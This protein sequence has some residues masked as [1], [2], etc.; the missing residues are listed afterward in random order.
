MAINGVGDVIA[1]VQVTTQ[2]AKTLHAA[3]HA[4]EEIRLFIRETDRYQACVG[5][6]A[7][8]LRRHGAIL[9]DHADVKSNI[10]S[11]LE[12]C[13]E[14]TRKLRR[15][16][17][18]YEHIVTKKGTATGADAA[19]NQWIEAFKTV[20]HSIEWTTKDV[21][22][23][24][25]RRELSRHIQILSWLENGLLSEQVGQLSVQ[26]SNLQ[27]MV[28]FAMSSPNLTPLSSP[29]GPSPNP[30][31]PS[32]TARGSGSQ[33]NSPEL[34]SNTQTQSMAPLRL[35]DPTFDID[36][37]DFG[38]DIGDQLQLPESFPGVTPGD[39]YR[40][41]KLASVK[42][43]KE[44]VDKLTANANFTEMYLNPIHFVWRKPGAPDG[45][46]I[47]ASDS[48]RVLLVKNGA[49][50][51]D[52]W[53]LN[54]KRTIRFRQ[55]VPTWE[56]II[57][58]S[59]NGDEFVAVV[60][61]GEGLT[62][63][64]I[65]QGQRRDHPRIPTTW[66]QY[67]FKSVLDCEQFQE[68][69]YGSR[70]RLLLPVTEICRPHRGRDDD[71]LV[72]LENVRVWEMGSEMRFMVHLIQERGK[73]RKKYMEFNLC[74]DSIKIES[75]GTGRKSTLLLTG[76]H[77]QIDEMESERRAS[78]STLNSDSTLGPAKSLTRRFSWDRSL[79][80]LDKAEIYFRHQEDRDSLLQL[81]LSCRP[82]RK[83]SG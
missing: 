60:E 55:R 14:T 43:Q 71:R 40:H 13:A 17:T 31:S 62:F 21:V 42:E 11:M 8:R 68:I 72:G 51:E 10:Q 53:T 64:T 70:L 29:F 1:L 74:Q 50:V 26:V 79:P 77:A 82:S 2:A 67:K 6:A 33:V 24:N 61:Q 69:V 28:A 65:Q 59:I 45:V 25:L 27:D 19:W 66:V 23:E 78:T 5:D 4:P 20:Y 80:Y 44:F 34:S 58:Y 47:E 81:A 30:T 76:I 39:Q 22:V 41:V 9:K 75:K 15:I 73:R 36:D 52:I 37:C 49:A 54:D 48:G 38:Q 7:S 63:F 18:K 3:T 56:Y 83:K 46:M 12:Q 32:I 35:P 57:P 16:A